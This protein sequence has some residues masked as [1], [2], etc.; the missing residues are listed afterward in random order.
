MKIGIQKSKQETSAR[1]FQP[2]RKL[3]FFIYA[4]YT[5]KWNKKLQSSGA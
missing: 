4:V 2:L 5:N 1:T 3:S